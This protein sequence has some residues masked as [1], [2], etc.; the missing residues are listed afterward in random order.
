M[1][2]SCLQKWLNPAP[3]NFP[4]H[5]RKSYLVIIMQHVTA[6]CTWNVCMCVC[7]SRWVVLLL[8]WNYCFASSLSFTS[9]LVECFLLFIF[10]PL[11]RREFSAEWFVFLRPTKLLQ[12]L[13]GVLWLAFSLKD[14][15]AHSLAHPLCNQVQQKLARSRSLCPNKIYSC[16]SP[17]CDPITSRK[18]QS[19]IKIH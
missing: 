6:A 12:S 2:K 10:S 15:P 1:C 13:G 14:N 9:L 5:N 19:Y 4:D 7:V 8:E 11:K 17:F 16:Y 3:L 18:H